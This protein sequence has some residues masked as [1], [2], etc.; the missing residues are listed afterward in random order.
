MHPSFVRPAATSAGRAGEAIAASDRCLQNGQEKRAI[1]GTVP[2]G[3]S[4]VPIR[5]ESEIGVR[6]RKSLP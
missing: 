4:F 3:R 2:I 6:S 1:A 5:P